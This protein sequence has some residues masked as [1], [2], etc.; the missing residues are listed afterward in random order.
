MT[1]SLELPKDLESELK[2]EAKQFGLTV[3]DYTLQLLRSRP[4]LQTSP[5]N[6]AE[7][8]QYWQNAGLIGYRNDIEDSQVYARRLRSQAE[9]RHHNEA[10]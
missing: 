6:G 8:I 5:H 4:Q 7:L 3:A 9:T 2:S 10:Q 1:L